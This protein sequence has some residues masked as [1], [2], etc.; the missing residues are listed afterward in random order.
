[1]RGPVALV[2][3][4]LLS[5]L[6]TL[7]AAAETGSDI[8]VSTHIEEYHDGAVLPPG[9]ALHGVITV[10]NRGSEAVSYTISDTCP[11]DAMVALP[12]GQVLWSSYQ[13]HLC[14][15][16]TREIVLGSGES[17]TLYSEVIS[18]D[19]L[20]I[21]PMGDIHIVLKIS[22]TELSDYV[23]MKSAPE[24]RLDRLNLLAES[25]AED[26]IIAGS[27]IEFNLV[28]QS[29]D[30]HIWD[31]YQGDC[32]VITTVVPTHGLPMADLTDIDCIPDEDAG[33]NDLLRHM[34]WLSVSTVLPNGELL[35]VGDL[36]V[37][38]EAGTLRKEFHFMIT[39]A[40]DNGA[41]Y[42]SLSIEENEVLLTNN[43]PFGQ[44]IGSSENP[45]AFV[46][47]RIDR[48][49]STVLSTTSC[50]ADN[51]Q[52]SRSS[53][54]N[55]GP[56]PMIVDQCFGDT[57]ALRL[58]LLGTI[59]DVMLEIPDESRCES[60]QIDDEMNVESASIVRDADI[61]ISADGTSVHWI[62]QWSD[63][64]GE[65]DIR[66]RTYGAHASALGS[67]SIA[68]CEDAT[69]LDSVWQLTGE[70]PTRIVNALASAN[71]HFSITEVGVGTI[72]QTELKYSPPKIVEPLLD[73]N[74]E[75]ELEG[76]IET[77]MTG[78]WLWR[79]TSGEGCWFFEEHP[80]WVFIGTTVDKWEPKPGL[81]GTYTIVTS[82][83][84]HDYCSGLGVSVIEVGDEA[85]V[86]MTVLSG[87]TDADEDVG[88]PILITPET[89]AITTSFS[90]IA[91]LLGYVNVESIRMP[92][93]RWGWIFAMGTVRRKP[94][95]GAYQRGR[96]IGYLQA[97]PG[98]HFR[99]LLNALD[100]SNGHLAHHLRVLEEREL[101]WKRRAGRR[102]LIYPST[103]SQDMEVEELPV[104]IFCPDPSSTQGKILTLLVGDEHSIGRSMTQ[105]ELSIRLDAS[106]QLVSHHLRT[107]QRYGLIDHDRRG[108]WNVYFPTSQA[109]M[110][111]SE[112]K[113][114]SN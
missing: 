8:V 9:A 22:H 59:V 107:L 113:R 78:S 97:N 55:L 40:L 26:E 77:T 114:A 64:R 23:V 94:R 99:A 37:I 21:I 33:I 109:R 63:T 11:V 31:R 111:Y 76:S 29:D 95:D 104:P 51:I 6:V 28:M 30:V 110:L 14:G 68:L 74:T 87:S 16:G 39:P 25:F 61:A 88:L 106:Q 27:S 32:R 80:S 42:L 91:I 53:T 84:I 2:S 5:G 103:I 101:I 43:A 18:L 57:D 70:H 82:N 79:T 52:I 54:L 19:E 36:R 73:L 100:M 47:D 71:I 96:I 46:L 83:E 41:E 10:M 67:T 13:R 12:N 3:I 65:C 17:I 56:V 1:M 86:P 92:I 93:S 89:V 72:H 38:I 60:S 62:L 50:S 85:S 112:R 102:V 15:D 58:T 108:V 98:V 90:I 44:S 48:T 24:V 66:I 35:P 81:I 49:G 20:D 34:G 7:G 105:R 4:L 75:D 45:C 69:H